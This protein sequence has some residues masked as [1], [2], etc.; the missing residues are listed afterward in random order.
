MLTAFYNQFIMSSYSAVLVSHEDVVAQLTQDTLNYGTSLGLN[1]KRFGPG[2]FP[3]LVEL[4][5]KVIL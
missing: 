3:Q 4:Q 2:K 1:G 5:F